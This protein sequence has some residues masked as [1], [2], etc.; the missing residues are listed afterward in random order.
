MSALYVNARGAIHAGK[1]EEF[2]KL[3]DEC[4]RLTREKDSGTLQYDWFLNAEQTAC[5]ILEHY[6]DSDAVLEHIANLGAM[7]GE[8]LGIC[9]WEFEVFGAPSAELMAAAA[10]LGPKVYSPLG[11]I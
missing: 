1:L 4:I 8:I 2:K 7:M 3:A 9:D 6:R 11:S 10:A 5:V